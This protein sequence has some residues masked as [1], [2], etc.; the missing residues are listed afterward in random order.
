[1]SPSKAITR[2]LGTSEIE[3]SA[4]GLGCLALGGPWERVHRG[5]A[6]Y[7]PGRIDPKEVIRGIHSAIDAGVTF[8]D[9]A[10]NY[11]AGGSERM[12]GTA[13][14]E[15]R[16]EVAIATKFG[17]WVDEESGKTNFYASDETSESLVEHIEEDCNASLRRLQTDWIDL[18]LF[19]VNGFPTEKAHLVRDRLEKLVAAGKIRGYGWSTNNTEGA[20]VFAQGEHC[21]A[22]EH[23]LNVMFDA[24]EMLAFCASR[25]LSNIAYSPLAAGLLS[26]KYRSSDP[27]PDEEGREM[28]Y[29][30]Q[31][32]RILDQLDAIR[33]ILTSNGRSLAQGALGWIWARSGKAIP[34]PGFRTMAQV[35][36]NVGALDK[37]PLSETQMQEIE[38]I[39]QR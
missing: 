39:L 11:G 29:G 36:D 3:V 5:G 17:Y 27:Q 30:T 7:D 19:H 21:Y 25:G 6:V 37:G 35:Q 4:L 8:F 1:M 10:A 33:D 22:I 28:G 32:G 20:R 23:H 9:T 34:I 38:D 16:N 13:L 18:Y 31:A 15:H 26:G 14:L 12:L 2:R 24:P